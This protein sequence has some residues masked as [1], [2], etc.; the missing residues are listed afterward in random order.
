MYEHDL[1]YRDKTYVNFCPNCK[2][3]LAN[4]ESQGGKCDRCDHDVVQMEK[5]FGS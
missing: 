2:V 3:I 4:E 1:A 5:M